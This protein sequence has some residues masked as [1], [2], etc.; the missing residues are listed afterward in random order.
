LTRLLPHGLRVLDGN[1]V[2]EVKS[3]EWDKG[4]LAQRLI[5]SGGYEF[6]LAAGDDQTDED[7]LAVLTQK[8]HFP[9]RVGAGMTHANYRLSDV[10]QVLALL[11][12]LANQ[13]KAAP[14]G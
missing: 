14:V 11:T 12:E 3:V 6:V 2:V 10:R 9:I 4:K 1:K 13:H 8:Q 5:A 7:M